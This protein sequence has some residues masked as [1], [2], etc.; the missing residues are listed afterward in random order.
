MPLIMVPLT[1]MQDV[2]ARYTFLTLRLA[3]AIVRTNKG[4]TMKRQLVSVGAS[5]IIVALAGCTPNVDQAKANFC[6]DLG[7]YAKAVAN[8]GALGPD[9]TVSD[10]NKAIKAE[11]DAYKKLEKAA[12]R[13]SAAQ[14]AAMKKV[15]QTFAKTYDN[16]K[17]S[18]KL[19]DA[20]GTIEQ[21]TAVMLDNYSDIAST[22]CVYGAP[23]AQAQ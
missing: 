6:K 23:E 9:S 10:L 20:A 7:A 2:L 3:S 8:V 11:N 12:N 21:A 16:I 1:S 4:K 13:L 22:T 14:S 5:A 18:E 17:G 15:D 19:G